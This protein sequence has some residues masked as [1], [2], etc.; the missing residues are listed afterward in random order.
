LTFQI[1]NTFVA[2]DLFTA[3]CSPRQ[4][5]CGRPASASPRNWPRS[6]TAHRL[7]AKACPS[8]SPGAVQPASGCLPC[9]A[10]AAAITGR[11][12]ER[13]HDPP[14]PPLRAPPRSDDRADEAQNRDVRIVMRPA[15]RAHRGGR[16]LAIHSSSRSRTAS[17]GRA[18]TP[19]R[20][21]GR[22]WPAELSRR[23][24][25]HSLPS[26]AVWHPCRAGQ[27]LERIPQVSRSRGPSADRDPS[28]VEHLVPCRRVQ[29]SAA[30]RRHDRTQL[31][32][33]WKDPMRLERVFQRSH[34][35]PGLPVNR[36][37][38][39]RVRADHR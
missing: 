14:D 38:R 5:F 12:V 24:P 32:G 4:H 30:T 21:A 8:A 13:W 22:R 31:L 7:A 10:T 3:P 6:A 17:P 18:P 9:R 28:P 33:P 15:D 26:A 27:E 39:W 34:Q 11:G 23:P 2:P 25:Q 29:G 35:E 16:A 37:P 19:R 1:L 36:R 20:L